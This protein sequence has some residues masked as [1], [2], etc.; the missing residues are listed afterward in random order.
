[1]NEPHNLMEFFKSVREQMYLLLISGVAGAF[2]R[3][4]IAPE[5][6]WKRRLAQ[7]VGG[8]MSAVFLGGVLA[9]MINQITDA[10]NMAYLAAGFIMGS[11]GELAIKTIQDRLMK[12]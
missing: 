7:G 3:A 5:E 6:N 8:A 9:H 1:M 4:I 11:G 2:F 10:G 12:K